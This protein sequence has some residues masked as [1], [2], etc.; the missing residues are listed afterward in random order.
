MLGAAAPLA[1]IEEYSV[2]ASVAAPEICRISKLAKSFDGVHFVLNGINLVVREGEAVALIGA[3]GCGKSTL[4]RCIAGL[5][6][7]DMGSVSVLGQSLEHLDHSALRRLRG[8]VGF[9]FQKHNLVG[10]LSA[11]SNVVHGVQARERGPRTWLQ[12]LARNEVR[13]EAIACLNQVGLGDVALQRASFLSGGQSQRVAIA[14][15]LM[16]RPRIILADEPDASL[17]PRAGREIMQ[18]L[19]DLCRSG[20][21]GLIF[22]S[23]HL[24]HALHFADRIVGLREGHIAIDRES[25]TTSP[26]ELMPLF[27]R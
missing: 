12:S 3:N 14:R 1:D 9:V 6:R 15:V 2:S 26:D 21:I 7:P 27:Q 17:D 13:A 19:R 24:E 16:Q 5:C 4:L 8:R 22:V 11:L 25:R 10:R 20:G 18:L 23:H